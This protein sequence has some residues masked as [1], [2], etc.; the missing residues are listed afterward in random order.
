MYNIGVYN[1]PPIKNEHRILSQRQTHIGHVIKC[2]I[3]LIQLHLT[4]CL[5]VM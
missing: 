5:Q 2:T 4:F 3:K 1:I